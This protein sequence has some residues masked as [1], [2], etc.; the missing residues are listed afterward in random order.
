MFLLDG[1]VADV[2]RMILRIRMF[3]CYNHAR[4]STHDRPLVGWVFLR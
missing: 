1:L 3:Q 4:E 2:D